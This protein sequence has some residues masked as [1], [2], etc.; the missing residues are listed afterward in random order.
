MIVLRSEY[1]FKKCF[2]HIKD[3]VEGCKSDGYKSICLA[4][5]NNT[6]GFV[7]FEKLCKSNEIKPIF[8]IRLDV[9]D[10]LIK[11]KS[12]Y[13]SY[14]EKVNFIFIAKNKNGM[15]ILYDLSRKSTENFYWIN[16]IY[17]N[18]I[19]NLSNDVYVIADRKPRNMNILL[20]RIDYFVDRLGSCEK[21]DNTIY[22]QDVR[23]PK[24]DDRGI[25]ELHSKSEYNSTYPMH[26]LSKDEA[27]AFGI[28]ESSIDNLA[29][30][31]EACQVKLD[32]ADMVKSKD[33]ND[34]EKKCKI[35]AIKL[36]IDLDNDVYKNRL[37]I[38]LK[39]IKDRNFVDYF[40]IVSDLINN[41]K[42][43]AMVGPGRGSAG[44]S[45]VCYLLGITNVDPIKYGLL[46]ERFIDITRSD[47]PDID[48][49]FLDT[50][51]QDVIKYITQ[52]Y[53]KDSVK[54]LSNISRMKPKSAINDFG[55]LMLIPASDLSDVKDAIIERSGGD[56]RASMC[57]KDTFEGTEAGKKFI[58]KYPEMDT[59]S[60]IEGHA[61]HHSTHAAGVLICSDKIS[62][63]CG[64]SERDNTA[65]IDKWD[66]EYLNLLKIDILGLRTLSILQETARLAKFD[67]NNFYKL[68]F[69]DPNV[70][71]VFNSGRLHA[72]FQFEGKALKIVTNQIK[73]ECFDD[74]VDITSLSRPGALNSGGTS[75]YIN[76]KNGTEQPEYFG[77]MY[78]KQTESTH[79]I[80]IYQEQVMT[81]LR[82]Y[83]N[84]SWED[85]NMLRRAISKSYGD[86]F[87]DKYKNKFI[88]GAKDNGYSE[89]N[90]KKV[91][92]AVASMGSYAFN[93]SHALAY[94]MISY[95]TAY[96]KF[97]HPLE[98]AAAN[99]NNVKDDENGIKILRDFVK[100]DNIEYIPF[101]PDKSDVNWTIVDGKLLGGFKNIDGIG[102][103]K[104]AKIISD[105]KSRKKLTKSVFDKIMS[106]KTKY[107]IL[108]PTEYHFGDIYKNYTKYGL[109]KR[110]SKIDE[111]HAPGE[112][113][114]I[115]CVVDRDLRDRNDI[116]SV[117]KRGNEVSSN[118]YYLNLYIE[119]DTDDIKCMI[120]PFSFDNLG[121][122]KIAEKSIPGKTWYIIMG[123]IRDKWRSLSID[124]IKDITHM[125][126]T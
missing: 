120:P 44:G 78:R 85:V 66:A 108:F 43:Y 7:K 114:I 56:A 124:D 111:V 103:A 116:Q 37:S 119:D 26:R 13:E 102:D 52:K 113:I 110:P 109:Q 48:I 89:D 75:S 57:I 126:R 104:A 72:I 4:D 96:C 87:F 23:Y 12:A 3:L 105:I 24:I 101:D 49:D 17:P 117:I 58:S 33:D 47:L 70:F 36:G 68:E 31:D 15:K 1:S 98:F 80:V 97:Y 10:C 106:G 81:I 32:K 122:S 28:K 19:C 82:E 86:E 100:N 90:A 41:E 76:R 115:G 107:D 6:Y 8:G 5:D 125:M 59:V 61:S 74:I 16:R 118:R 63:Y 51:R 121:G 14:N 95:W 34:I 46:F 67:F 60:K 84:L 69:D 39:L 45:L 55:K 64:V 77:D 18:D 38:E 29:I 65:M 42:K 2:Y 73:I 11:A 91:W 53:G 92:Q 27:I 62:N 79:G 30:I 35:G 71:S 9:V 50:R 112:Y 88:S 25:F 123:S 93:K 21:V 54:M 99:M 22:I 20:K 94:S 83:G 40:I